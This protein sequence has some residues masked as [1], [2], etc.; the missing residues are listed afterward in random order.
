MY[1]FKNVQQKI[2]LLLNIFKNIQMDK[3]K[4]KFIGLRCSNVEYLKYSLKL[5]Q[6]NEQ[7]KKE[8]LKPFKFSD[9]LRM[10][11]DK[12]ILINLNH[13]NNV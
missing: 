10:G 4:D 8:G 13:E 1:I 6:I 3:D 11:L 5:A 9:F 7:R 12:L 2:L